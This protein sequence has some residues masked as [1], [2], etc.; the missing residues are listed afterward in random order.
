MMFHK[1]LLLVTLFLSA[2]SEYISPYTGYTYTRQRTYVP[3]SYS[4]I[5]LDPDQILAQSTTIK[6]PTTTTTI[7]TYSDVIEPVPSTYGSTC[8]TYSESYIPVGEVYT[9]DI[10]VESENYYEG[11]GYEVYGGETSQIEPVENTENTITYQPIEP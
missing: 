6:E 8:D 2:N 11:S 1:T 5:Q 4:T 7:D 10:P 3:P 9:E